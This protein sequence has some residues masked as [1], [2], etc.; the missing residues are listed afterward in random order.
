MYEDGSRKQINADGS[1]IIREVDGTESTISP[2]QQPETPRKVLEPAFAAS[3]N[4]R[5]ESSTEFLSRRICPMY[6]AANHI[7]AHARPTSLRLKQ[8]ST[9]LATGPCSPGLAAPLPRRQLVKYPISI[10]GHHNRLIWR[11]LQPSSS[12]SM[13]PLRQHKNRRVQSQRRCQCQTLQYLQM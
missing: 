5:H 10:L 2:A 11:A 8:S 3:A 12:A 13:A 1:A 7:P 4:V 6:H 9:Q